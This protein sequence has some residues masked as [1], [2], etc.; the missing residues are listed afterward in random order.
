MAEE[1]PSHGRG[2]S[3]PWPRGG[4]SLGGALGLVQALTRASRFYTPHKSIIYVFVKS[5]KGDFIKKNQ[6]FFYV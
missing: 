2:G 4:P 1:G 5:Q 6:I 3:F